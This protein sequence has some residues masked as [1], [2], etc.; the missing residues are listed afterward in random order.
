MEEPH[1]WNDH[2]EAQEIIN[3][4]HSLKSEVTLWQDLK[5]EEEELSQL[6]QLADEEKEESLLADI[7]EG[8]KNLNKGLEELE[9]KSLL[10]DK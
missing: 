3:R 9:L 4:V 5:K 2:K 10:R 7:R 6:L 8:K 1:F